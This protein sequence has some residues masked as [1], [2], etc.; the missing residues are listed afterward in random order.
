[1]RI[2]FIEPHLKLFGGIRHVLE[3]GNE[4]VG[5][6]HEVVLYIPRG[7]S[8]ECT[9]MECRPSVRYLGEANDDALDAVI[10]N[11]EPDFAYLEGFPRARLRVF[12]LLHFASLYDK[13]FSWISYRCPS[14]CIWPRAAGSRS[15]CS[16]RSACVPW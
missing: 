16:A 12:W 4:L 7:Q 10:F 11:N 13:A 2:A 5:L 9:W 8:R 15:V 14:I 1:M 6:G 3:I